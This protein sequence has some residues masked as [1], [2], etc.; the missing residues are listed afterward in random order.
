MHVHAVLDEVHTPRNMPYSM[1][2]DDSQLEALE[3]SLDVTAV[4]NS[5][6]HMSMPHNAV[7]NARRPQANSQ[8]ICHHSLGS[9]A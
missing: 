8:G 1:P 6:A 5:L 9:A 4:Q 3:H 7:R 2:G